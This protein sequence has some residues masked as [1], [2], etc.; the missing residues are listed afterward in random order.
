MI[1]NDRIRVE[2]EI[3]EMLVTA[4]APVAAE[5]A[6]RAERHWLEEVP[7]GDGLSTGAAETIT[8]MTDQTLRT[9]AEECAAAGKAIGLRVV[10]GSDRGD[11]WV[12]SLARLLD[13]IERRKGK[14]R[15]VKVEQRYKKFVSNLADAKK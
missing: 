4:L 14:P 13:E 15:R 8:G 9:W 7:L 3:R 2:A 1:S 5:V 6:R 10:T 12:I 11:G